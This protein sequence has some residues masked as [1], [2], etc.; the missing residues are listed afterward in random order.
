M[1]TNYNQGTSALKKVINSGAGKNFEVLNGSGG[2]IP[3]FNADAIGNFF[4]ENLWNEAVYAIDYATSSGG[5][6][7]GYLTSDDGKQFVKGIRLSI[8]KTGEDE[9]EVIQGLPLVNTETGDL[10]GE[11]TGTVKSDLTAEELLATVLAAYDVGIDISFWDNPS[12]STEELL[13]QLQSE[14][15]D[16]QTS[17]TTAMG[18]SA[19]GAISTINSFVYSSLNSH[20]LVLQWLWNIA[21]H[22][23]D[24]EAKYI[25]V[26]INKIVQSSY[27]DNP[28]IH[29]NVLEA[30]EYYFDSFY[31]PAAGNGNIHRKKIIADG[32]FYWYRL[33][34]SI[35]NSPTGQLNF[36]DVFIGFDSNVNFKYLDS[37]VTFSAS[38]Y[39][40]YTDAVAAFS[41]QLNNTLTDKT[42]TYILTDT[43]DGER[44]NYWYNNNYETISS[45]T[46]D[47]ITSFVTFRDNYLL[48]HDDYFPKESVFDRFFN[49]VNYVGGAV[50]LTTGTLSIRD[51]VIPLIGKTASDIINKSST[52]GLHGTGALDALRKV[53]NNIFDPLVNNI[54]TTAKDWLDTLEEANL[55][56]K[57][58]DEDHIAQ[59]QDDREK[60]PNK[61]PLYIPAPV[62][63]P[64]NDPETNPDNDLAKRQ[65]PETY[66]PLDP[67]SNLN[68]DINPNI[69]RAPNSNQE[70][71]QN[72]SIENTQNDPDDDP[73]D[74]SNKK[75][76]PPNSGIVP[77]SNLP[78]VSASA[79]FNVHMPSAGQLSSFAAYLWSND[80]ID[81]LKKMF[82]DPMQAIVSLHQLYATPSTSGNTNIICGYLDS[83]VSAPKVSNQFIT[84]NCGSV[85]VPKYYNN[86]MD[87]APYTDLQLYLPFIGFVHLSNAE[88]MGATITV[89]Y[90][91]DVY[92]GQCVAHVKVVKDGLSAILYQYGGNC[93]VQLPYSGGNW[94]QFIQAGIGI[95]AGAIATGVTGGAAAPLLAG[96]ATSLVS[97]DA[98]V[99]RGGSFGQSIGALSH[100]KPYL[101]ID[102]KNAHGPLY[103]PYGY[104]DNSY[105][106]LSNCSGYVRI[107]EVNLSGVQATGDELKEIELLLKEG[108][109][110]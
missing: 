89:T 23:G 41:E 11:Y 32:Q 24:V 12:Q 83:G 52:K 66:S 25:P 20:A 63:I 65:T 33:T 54:N 95:V 86:V 35:Y 36:K 88:C 80:F 70:K 100:K 7:N 64:W 53:P 92:S 105:V 82:S 102:R 68:P 37:T 27:S 67:N 16:V 94:S 8:K 45:T 85:K 51:L 42:S 19:N 6:A 44:R 29:A 90:N 104:G 87:N 99:S 49:N 84:L 75:P 56:N 97:A 43:F 50:L 108:V 17:V 107:K 10:T 14:L 71:K 38:D 62:I 76:T 98:N 21:N 69:N 103:Q 59:A 58:Y 48:S 4:A 26:T 39:T 5:Y 40:D 1:S 60:N 15:N 55:P 110:V 28:A 93:S 79:M 72:R 109:I 3:S 81:N 9:Y 73:D 18:A 106:K 34:D 46:F 22:T 101:I 77:P 91:I 31:I 30:G 74:S 61:F 47:N 2:T 13:T 96:A 57:Y 78:S